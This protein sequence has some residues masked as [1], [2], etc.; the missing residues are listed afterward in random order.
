MGLASRLNEQNIQGGSL[1][2][3]VN[4]VQNSMGPAQAVKEVAEQ[5][6]EKIKPKYR[7]PKPKIPK[8]P[9]LPKPMGA[10][11]KKGVKGG[12][13]KSNDQV[14][15][16]LVEKKGVPEKSAKKFVEDFKEVAGWRKSHQLIWKA[17]NSWF[18]K[19]PII[20]EPDEKKE[21]EKKDPLDEVNKQLQEEVRR[22]KREESERKAREKLRKQDDKKAL[23]E[24]EKKAKEEEKKAKA[25][26][27]KGRFFILNARSFDDVRHTEKPKLEHKKLL[28]DYFN[29]LTLTSYGA[30][31]GEFVSAVNKVKIPAS[32]P[33]DEKLEALRGVL[34]F[35]RVNLSKKEAGEEKTKTLKSAVAKIVKEK[36]EKKKAPRVPVKKAKVK[37]MLKATDPKQKQKAKPKARKAKKHTGGE[38]RLIM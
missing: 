12:M 37:K 36:T 20:P 31:P 38:I 30:L 9:R 8:I 7:I 27:E 10:G 29:E 22:K 18:A 4:L 21:E 23:K 33:T 35:W 17:Y 34:D 11:K 15:I 3:F 2:D 6:V 16:W 28:H 1:P 13:A 32:K 19:E 26:K 5:I 24:I 14:V 25:E